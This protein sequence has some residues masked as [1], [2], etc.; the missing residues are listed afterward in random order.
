MG[1]EA[2]KTVNKNI[3]FSVIMPVFN[4]EHIVHNAIKSIL[5]QCYSN[6]ELILVDD[7]STDNTEAVC[8]KI[9]NQDN[10]II[11]YKKENG[12]VS[13]ARN[14]GLKQ[15][16]GDYVVFLDSDDSLDNNCLSTLNK[17]ISDTDDAFDFICYGTASSSEKIWK[18]VKS[19][20]PVF[21]G[22]NEI[23]NYYLPAHIN[24]YPQTT[25]FLLNYIWNKCFSSDFLKDN[26]L[27]FDEGRKTWEDGIFNVN[28]LDKAKNA[29]LIPEVLHTAYNDPTI[30][31]LSSNFYDSQIT[32]YL[33]DETTLKIRF[34]THYDFTSQHYCHS[35]LNV[36]KILYSKAYKKYGKQSAKLIETTAKEPIVKHWVLN[37]VPQTNWEKFLKKS[38]MKQ[39]Y[40]DIYNFYVLNEIKN[41][42]FSIFK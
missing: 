19:E 20:T 10:R 37:V 25:N 22:E 5:D 2:G 41:K 3:L 38:I 11:Y 16:S 35:N 1:R 33:Q 21:I 24:I 40:K 14:F 31:H 18:P 17:Y 39:H 34:E 28:C 12:G 23:K 6:W 27:H 4:R 7:G 32:N 36:L 15:M 9:A 42:I 13:S 30:D 26:N 29:L 8:K